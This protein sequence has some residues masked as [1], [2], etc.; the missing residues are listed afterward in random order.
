MCLGIPLKIVEINGEEAL[1][2]SGGLK[3]TIR[4]DFVPEAKPGDYVIVHAG[5]AISVLEEEE[6]QETLKLLRDI[7]VIT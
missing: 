5:F 2:E 7:D 6:A 3:Q 4:L 1:V